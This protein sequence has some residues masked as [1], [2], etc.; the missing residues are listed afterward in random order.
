MADEETSLSDSVAT[1]AAGPKTVAVAGMGQSEEH[2]LPDQIQAAKFKPL[3]STQK[4]VGGGI[5]FT[6]A[7]AGGAV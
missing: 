5:R 7:T 3:P 2:P 4:K 6:K 1:S